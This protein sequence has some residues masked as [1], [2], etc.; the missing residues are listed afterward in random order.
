MVVLETYSM[1]PPHLHQEFKRRYNI[2]H[3]LWKGNAGLNFR[4]VCHFICGVFLIKE[5]ERKVHE[6]SFG[7]R[8]GASSCRN[9]RTS[10]RLRQLIS[11]AM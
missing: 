1:T 10:V 2:I 4:L 5:R 8:F 7:A 3:M 9:G 11:G 6:G